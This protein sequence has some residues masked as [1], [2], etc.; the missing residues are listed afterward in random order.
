[1]K[2]D[3]RVLSVQEIWSGH[4]SVTGGLTDCQTEGIP[5]TPL[6]ASQWGIKNGVCCKF[7]MVLWV[8]T[9]F[10]NGYIFRRKM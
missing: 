7:L 6:S 9:F 10:I 1:M 8:K 5:I 4:E 3:Q 2:I